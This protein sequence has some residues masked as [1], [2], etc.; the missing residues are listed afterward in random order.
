MPS[1][2]EYVKKVDEKKATKGNKSNQSSPF[3]SFD[4]VSDKI[5]EIIRNEPIFQTNSKNDIEEKEKNNPFNIEPREQLEKKPMKPEF[6]TDFMKEPSVIEVNKK[7]ELFEIST[8]KKSISIP[9]HIAKQKKDDENI[10]TSSHKAANDEPV[11][12]F[13]NSSQS[14][15]KEKTKSKKKLLPFDFNLFS[16]KKDDETDKDTYLSEGNQQIQIEDKPEDIH[17]KEGFTIFKKESKKN[18]DDETNTEVSVSEPIEQT[19]LSAL[20]QQF[21]NK[22]SAAHN[23]PIN[24]DVLKLL[25]ITDE[26][27][28]KLPEDVISE[29]A[30]SEDFVLYEKVMKKYQ[31]L[32]DKS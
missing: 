26:L 21:E 10:Q 16:K 28:G 2:E 24:E 22:S 17:K 29:F 32:K 7:E 23:Q 12:H 1:Y 3:S 27:L 8:P 30:E 4:H 6:K 20:T 18:E 13:L 11:S 14:H 19:E 31:I 9:L 25:A 5:D 15:D